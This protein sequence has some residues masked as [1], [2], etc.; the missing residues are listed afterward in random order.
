MLLRGAFLRNTD[1]IFGVVI[2]TGLDTKIMKN[3]EP[4]K[5]KFSD[6]ELMMN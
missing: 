2:Y 1:W 4:S 3:A 5:V 6:M